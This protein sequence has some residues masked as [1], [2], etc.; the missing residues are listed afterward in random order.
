MPTG[1]TAGVQDGS[2]KTFKDY[3]SLCARAFTALIELRDEPFTPR[4]PDEIKSN[5][6]Y[7]EKKIEED[8]QRL[9]EAKA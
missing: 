6:T 7:T 4:L 8:A 3:A 9:A 2:I 5:T 1:Y